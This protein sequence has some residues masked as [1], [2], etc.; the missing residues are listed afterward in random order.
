MSQL[1]EPVSATVPTAIPRAT[2]QGRAR[3]IGRRVLFQREIGVVT[4]LAVLCLY[5]S[6]GT[7]GFA[8]KTNLLNVGQQVSLIGIMAIGMTFVIVSGEID[9]SVGSTYALASTVTGLLIEHGHSWIVAVAAGLLAGAACGLV[10]GLVTVGLGLPSFIVT[11][12]T[13]SVI[14]GI[15]LLATN[16]APIT[17]DQ[18]VDNVS[19]F[20]YLGEGRPLGIPMQLVIMLALVAAGGFLLRYTRFGFRVYA[21]GGS[22]EAAR[23][24][25]IPVAAVRV[26]SFVI[27]GT[28]SAL[29]G[30]LGL[31]FLLYSQGTTGTGLEL[32]VITAVIIGGAALFGGSGTMVG[33][34]VGVFL[35]G[36]LQNILVLAN[37]SS[38][39]Q[40]IVIG[41]VIVASVAL[42]TWVR[43]RSGGA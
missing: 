7:D 26:A 36:A 11:L 23:L 6:F 33:T 19:K 15:A 30:I 12:G 24:C 17:L 37:V 34:L 10:N 28:L 18:T 40:T 29:A 4:A 3:E 9:L 2:A 27:A 5:G 38:F 13:L 8:A 21:V 25:G 42:D 35:I 22:R 32:L 1:D 31:S 39:W 14:R 20:S 41:V 43:R 16:A